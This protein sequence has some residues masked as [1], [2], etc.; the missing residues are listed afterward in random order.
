MTFILILAQ[1]AT[2]SR[3]EQLQVYYMDR[4]RNCYS[5]GSGPTVGCYSNL[6]CCGVYE[7]VIKYDSGFIW[8]LR[9]CFAVQHVQ[10]R[11]Y[12]NTV[13]I[14]GVRRL[15]SRPRGSRAGRHQQDCR[16]RQLRVGLLYSHT[17]QCQGQGPRPHNQGSGQSACQTIPVITSQ[18][19]LHNSRAA[20]VSRRLHSTAVI[21]CASQQRAARRT[22]PTLYLINPTSLAKTGAIQQLEADLITHDIDIALVTETHFNTKQLDLHLQINN[23]NLF[24]RDRVLGAKAKGGGVCFYVKT[25]FSAKVFEPSVARCLDIEILWLQYSTDCFI[26]CVYNP[27]RP[28]YQPVDFR[29]ALL[30]DIDEI[31]TLFPRSVIIIAGDFNQI[32]TSFLEFDYGFYQIVTEKTHGD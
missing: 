2:N 5:C 4:L 12:A 23:Y 32:D 25:G 27:P 9:H 22:L 13:R 11:P 26:A 19:R 14:L 8:S 6:T 7:P 28:V 10:A 17:G 3:N 24:R 30:A 1:Q 15:R 21:N 20:T 31:H 29:N 16:Q 18:V